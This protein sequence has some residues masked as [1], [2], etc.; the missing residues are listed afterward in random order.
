MLCCKP[1]DSSDPGD[2]ALS[3]PQKAW[4]AKENREPGTG[5]REPGTGNQ[6]PG[7]RTGDR[8]PGTRN[9]EPGTGNQEPGTRTGDR[10]PGTGNQEPGTRNRE[11]GTRNR[12]PGTGTRNREPGTGNQDRGPETGDREPGTRNREPGT[13]DQEPGTRN[14]EPGIGDRGPKT[15]LYAPDS[16]YPPHARSAPIYPTRRSRA[17]SDLSDP[18]PAGRTAVGHPYTIAGRRGACRHG[19]PTVPTNLRKLRGKVTRAKRGPGVEWTPS[20]SPGGFRRTS[21][22]R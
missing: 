18:N 11:P 15:F 16:P 1:A 7:T 3:L 17:V 5:N 4:A 20:T 14:R 13:G 10:R 8:G 12:E 22:S 6:E 2:I 9:R 19:R 21:P